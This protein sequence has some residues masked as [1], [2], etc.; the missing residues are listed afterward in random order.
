MG[1]WRR[2]QERFCEQQGQEEDLHLYR[3]VVS[4]TFPLLLPLIVDDVDV[5]WC[6]LHLWGLYL[7]PIEGYHNPHIGT[8]GWLMITL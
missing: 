2:H 6:D 4:G 5:M 3:E 7:T 8:M 1:F